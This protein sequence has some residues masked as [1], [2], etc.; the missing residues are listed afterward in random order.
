MHRPEEGEDEICSALIE[1]RD[2]TASPNAITAAN[3]VIDTGNS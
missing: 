1:R 2:R 3:N